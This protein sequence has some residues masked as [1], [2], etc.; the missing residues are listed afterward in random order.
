MEISD[1][2]GTQP[3]LYFQISYEVSKKLVP[4]VLASNVVAI[5]VIIK[6]SKT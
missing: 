1:F 4:K 6:G 5:N 2:S 3:L